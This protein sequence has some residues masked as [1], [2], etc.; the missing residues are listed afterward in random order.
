M[1]NPTDDALFWT[2][3]ERLAPVRTSSG[4]RSLDAPALTR[5]PWEARAR[6]FGAG[7]LDALARLTRAQQHKPPTGV[8][9]PRG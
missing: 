2:L 5:G 7:V 8:T 9:G 6:G 4:P 1:P 3:L